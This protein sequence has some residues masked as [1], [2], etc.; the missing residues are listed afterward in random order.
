VQPLKKTAS[1][2]DEMILCALS[3]PRAAGRGVRK[4]VEGISLDGIDG[5]DEM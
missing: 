1:V 2:D 4:V 3:R 5:L